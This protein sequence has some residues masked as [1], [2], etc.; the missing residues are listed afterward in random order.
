MV[1][2]TAQRH[3][4]VLVHYH[5][6]VLSPKSEVARI[7]HELGWQPREK[8]WELD[9]YLEALDPNRA[10][11]TDFQGERKAEATEQLWKNQMGLSQERLNELQAVLDGYGYAMHRMGSIAPLKKG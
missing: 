5:D 6:L 8:D 10:S 4:I 7:V 11:D 3:D 9:A 2:E 1:Q